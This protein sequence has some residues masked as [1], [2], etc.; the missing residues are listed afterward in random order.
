MKYKYSVKYN[1]GSTGI[2][3][4]DEDIDFHTLHNTAIAFE[5]MYI[6]MANVIYIQKQIISDDEECVTYDVLD[7]M[8]MI[9]KKHKGGAE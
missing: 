3:T 4:T 6:N 5:D 2:F 7:G 1:D 9:S 8:P